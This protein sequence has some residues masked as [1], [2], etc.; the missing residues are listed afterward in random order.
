[1]T[2]DLAET[3]GRVEHHALE[4]KSEI[5]DRNAIRVNRFGRGIGLVRATLA[6]NGNPPPQFTVTPS[7]WG[8][9]LRAAR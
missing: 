3:L 2:G 4:F 5:V 1:M 8:V 6:E 9:T 7:Y